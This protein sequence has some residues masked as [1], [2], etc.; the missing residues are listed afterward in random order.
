MN[1]RT[2]RPIIPFLKHL[3]LNRLTV[4]LSENTS[5]LL[6]TTT[7]EVNRPFNCFEVFVLLG[8]TE[9]DIQQAN[10]KPLDQQ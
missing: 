10:K 4:R 8:T 9:S 3:I 5:L 7:S 1:I 2:F 6:N